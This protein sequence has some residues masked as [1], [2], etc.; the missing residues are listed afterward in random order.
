MQRNLGSSV[1]AFNKFN[2]NS[3]RF[4]LHGQGITDHYATVGSY[5]PVIFPHPLYVT[6]NGDIYWTTQDRGLWRLTKKE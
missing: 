6:G 4:F 2:S 1:S 3:I 5:P